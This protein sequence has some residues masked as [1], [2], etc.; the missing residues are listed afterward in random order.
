MRLT[1]LEYQKSTY[2]ASVNVR[3]VQ[4]AARNPLVEHNLGPTSAPSALLTVMMKTEETHGSCGTQD[5]VSSSRCSLENFGIGSTQVV[6]AP[7]C[8]T[9]PADAVVVVRQ[10]FYRAAARF[11]IAVS[12]M[13]H[14]S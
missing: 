9:P 12:Q 14:F 8:V 4:E 7:R 5:G 13:Q 6:Y 11:K 10:R 3:L 1:A 2:H